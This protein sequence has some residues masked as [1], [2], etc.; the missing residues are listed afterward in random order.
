MPK[1]CCSECF[2]DRGLTKIISSKNPTLGTCDFCHSNDVALIDPAALYDLFNM[3]VSIYEK[4]PSGKLLV[5]WLKDDWFLF[6]HPTMDIPHTKDLLSE[7]LDNGEIVRQNF[8]PSPTYISDGLIRWKTLRD[9]L[10]YK[11]RYF[12]DEKLDTDRL[13]ELLSHLPAEEVPEIWYRARIMTSDTP[14]SIKE[15]GAPPNHLAT[16]GRANPIGIPYLY[17]GSMPETSISEVRPHTGDVVCVAEFK[18]P[19]L[20]LIDLRN[21]RK[22]VSPFVLVD[23]REIGQMRADIPFLEK[24]GIELTRPVL[25]RSAAIDYLPTQYFCEFIKKSGYD[26][27]VFRSSVSEGMNLAIFDPSNAAGGSISLHKIDRVSV[28]V[29]P[30]NEPPSTGS[31]G[32]LIPYEP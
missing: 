27:V 17:L 25:P 26:G 28:E 13:K 15:M 8:S 11:N 9:E 30:A 5:N 24:L 4:N 2:G 7:I 22:L 23:A 19:S 29:S 20:S 14:Y 12:L 16:H 31:Q 21:P 3:V 32:V 10:M 1:R 6:S 18:I